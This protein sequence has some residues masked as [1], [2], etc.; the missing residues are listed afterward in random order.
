MRKG[1]GLWRSAATFETSRVGVKRSADVSA[2][3]ARVRCVEAVRLLT[4]HLPSSLRIVASVGVCCL[5]GQVGLLAVTSPLAAYAALPDGRAYELVSPPT[6]GEP[7]LPSTSGPQPLGF[8]TLVPFRAAADGDAFVYAGEPAVLTGTGAVGPG[9]GNQWRVTRSSTGWQAEDITPSIPSRF[10]EAKYESFS[11]DL[12]TGFFGGNAFPLSADVESGCRALYSRASASGTFNPL[13]TAGEA[14]GN[15]GNPLFAGAADN[16]SPVILQSEAALAPGAE[17]ATE[18]PSGHEEHRGST[19]GCLFGCNLY[20]SSGGHLRT[21]NVLEGKPAPGAELGGYGPNAEEAPDFSNA[22]SNDGSRIFWTDI[23][24]GLSNVYVLENGT[25]TV[26]VSGGQPAEYWGASPDGHYAIYTEGGRLWRFDSFANSREPLTA[27]GSEVQGVIGFNQTAEARGYP[28]EGGGY[29]Y[30][31]AKAVLSSAPNGQ[32][33]HATPGGFNLY[34][35]HAGSETFIAGLSLSDN[36]LVNGAAGEGHIGGDWRSGL[37]ERTAEVTPDGKHLAF[38]SVQALTGYQSGLANL[39]EM[40]VYTADD[41][42][43]ACASCNPTGTPFASQKEPEQESKAPASRNAQTYMERWLSQDGK[44]VFF[45]SAQPLSP[46][47]RN[48]VSDVYEWERVAAP[49]EP[50]NTCTVEI[51][52]PVTGGCTFLLSGGEGTISSVLVDADAT[53]DNVFFE[54]FGQLGPVEAAVDHHELYDAR[55]GG[56]FPTTTVGCTAAACQPSA[57]APIAPTPPAST[58]FAGVGNFPTDT[59]IQSSSGTKLLTRSQRLTR[60]L[61]ACKKF[62]HSAKRHNCERLARRKYAPVNPKRSRPS[63]RRTSNDRRGHS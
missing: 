24:T 2:T 17:E 21:V 49:G 7:Y 23:P 61:K 15:C 25:N 43:L 46:E 12:A 5:V 42:Q 20:V 63:A 3:Q 8:Q 26:A 29:V 35:L 45:D 55:V 39:S 60:A 9:E 4:G 10:G 30:L 38:Q 32:G 33:E 6:E 40:F 14:P 18:V 11:S 51:A 47:D 54:H 31:V 48:Q 58:T 41:A 56:G 13:F 44:R 34:L 28:G 19:A 50:G 1:G 53:G 22:I 36:N 52:S 27:E 37:S 57:S 59:V 16:G 62:K